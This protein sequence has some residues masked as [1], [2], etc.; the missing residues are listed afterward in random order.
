M[1]V[2]V[3]SRGSSV[4]DR[5]SQ[6]VGVM[7]DAGVSGV[8]CVELHDA[9]REFCDLLWVLD[10]RLVAGERVDQPQLV[11]VV[12][13]L[14]VQRSM[15]SLAA[16]AAARIASRVVSSTISS[17][18]SPGMSAD[19]VE[20]LLADLAFIAESRFAEA[21]EAFEDAYVVPKGSRGRGRVGLEISEAFPVLLEVCRLLDGVPDGAPLFA[22]LVADRLEASP[23]ELARIVAAL[24]SA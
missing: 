9:R 20:G 17:A 13:R 2:S 6:L 16:G 12:L 22:A 8:D 7:L 23:V 15:T 5:L 1:G 14:S 3:L 18:V 11:E 4:V 19:W 24:H 21:V 10:G